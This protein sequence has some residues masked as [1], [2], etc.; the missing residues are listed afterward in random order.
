MM[1]LKAEKSIK[2]LSNVTA[3]DSVTIR[4]TFNVVEGPPQATNGWDVPA[5]EADNIVGLYEHGSQ[6]S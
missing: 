1:D 6:R 4:K 5:L 3:K 2:F